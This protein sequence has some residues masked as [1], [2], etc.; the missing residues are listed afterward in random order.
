MTDD[1]KAYASAAKFREEDYDD[2]LDD[3]LTESQSSRICLVHIIEYS[4]PNHLRSIPPE[5]ST[6]L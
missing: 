6:D 5:K 4:S 3:D 1:D 2:N